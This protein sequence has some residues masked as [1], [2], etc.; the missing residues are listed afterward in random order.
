ME[1]NKTAFFLPAGFNKN[2][3]ILSRFEA[4]QDKEF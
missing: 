4:W 3:K 1:S 2:A